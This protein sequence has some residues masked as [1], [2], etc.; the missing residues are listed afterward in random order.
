MDRRMLALWC[1]A[2]FAY[3]AGAAS[4]WERVGERKDA[5]DLASYYY[6][7]KVTEADGNPY[8]R[9][10]L[11]EVARAEGTRAAVHPYFYPPPALL[12]VAWMPR[13]TLVEAWRIW[14]WADVLAGALAIGTLAAWWR[15]LGPA[16]GVSLAALMALL[17]ALPNNH[18]MGQ[19]N[20]MVLLLVVLG[21][22][23][24][25]RGRWALAGALMGLACMTKMSPAVFVAWWL[26]RW[27]WRA[28]AAACVT[29]VL[30][31][32]LTLPLLSLD[33]QIDFYARV[34]PGFS[35]GRY[36][37]LAIPIDLFG[38]HSLVDLYHRAFPSHRAGLS[39]ISQELS[40]FSAALLV[41]AA[42]VAFW[43]EPR[44]PLQRA[45]QLGAVSVAALLIPVY[46]YEHHLVMAIPAVAAGAVALH[47]GRLGRGWW[48]PWA[49]A[50]A[51]FCVDLQVLRAVW[52]WLDPD[53]PVLAFLVREAK[54]A[55]LVTLGLASAVVGRSQRGTLPASPEPG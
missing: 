3:L 40:R 15:P 34:L 24:E 11:T 17:T 26:L 5:A 47:T 6:A 50:F 49:L 14:F 43:W 1:L 9:R 19:I 29:A 23:A 41:L 35:T 10:S 55:A 20:L 22:W 8:V 37:G 46:T 28:V 54:F 33:Y 27:R 18:L 45:G 21:L 32:A 44:D 48:A 16:V 2:L 12:W 38:N 25:E 31:S 7:A 51:V 4:A 39:G 30:L 53:R 13:V 52:L 36:N 42:A